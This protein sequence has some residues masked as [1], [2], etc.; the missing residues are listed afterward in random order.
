MEKRNARLVVAVE[1]ARDVAPLAA[2]LRELEAS[3]AAIET[4]IR[5]LRPIPRLAP[6]VIENRLTEW[7]RLLPSS[8]TRGE[9]FSSGFYVGG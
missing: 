2:Q 7:R 3:R 9:Q 6:A 8:T 1:T 4:E 5:S